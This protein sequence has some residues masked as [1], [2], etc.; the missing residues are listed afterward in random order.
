MTGSISEMLFTILQKIAITSI[1][2]IIIVRLS[3]NIIVRISECL[4]ISFLEFIIAI[5]SKIIVACI[6]KTATVSRHLGSLQLSAFRKTISAS[7]LLLERT[8]AS[9]SGS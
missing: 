9:K 8:H 6:S 7:I 3:K 1:S 4:A 2:G 5:I